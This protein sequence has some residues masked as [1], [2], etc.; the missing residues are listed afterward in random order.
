MAD[1][2]TPL[3]HHWPILQ[4]FPNEI[5]VFQALTATL[6]QLLCPP[7]TKA[8]SLADAIKCLLLLIQQE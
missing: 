5:P 1:G 2:N 6:D 7:A 3:H 4:V 8:N